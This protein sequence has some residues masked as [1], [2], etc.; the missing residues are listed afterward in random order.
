MH[1]IATVTD[2][3]FDHE[4]AS[5]PTPVLVEFS[6]EWCGPCKAMEPEIK[7]IAQRFDGRL[8]VVI[9]DGDVSPRTA[10]RL[11][12]R[13]FPTVVVFKNG[14]EVARQLGAV[15]RTKLAAMCEPHL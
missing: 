9:V 3:T 6:A 2:E 12:V 14:A 15:S 1:D 5:N 10:Q 11:R 7:A 4:V 8:K 13:G